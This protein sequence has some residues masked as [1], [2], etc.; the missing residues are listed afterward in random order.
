MTQARLAAPVEFR[1]FLGLPNPLQSG[2]MICHS[3]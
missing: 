3:A 2:K 1:T